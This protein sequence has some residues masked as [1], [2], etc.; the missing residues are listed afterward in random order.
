[1]KTQTS[2]TPRPT[3][4]ASVRTDQQWLDQLAGRCPRRVQ[5]QAHQDLAH[6]LYRVAFTYLLR[7]RDDVPLLHGWSG[8][9]LAQLAQGFVQKQLETLARHDFALLARYGGHGPFLG[10]MTQQLYGTITAKL[11]VWNTLQHLADS[12]EGGPAAR[13]AAA[14]APSG[15]E[16]PT[17]PS[18]RKA[19]PPIVTIA[20]NQFLFF[21][22]PQPVF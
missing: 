5:R 18:A 19:P 4:D 12:V 17:S 3:Q 6:Y 21:P 2:Q 11:H 9:E 15:L 22:Q 20:A 10:W 13:E 16:W 7:Q 8:E 1:M 14:D